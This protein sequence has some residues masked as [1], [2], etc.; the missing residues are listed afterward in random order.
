VGGHEINLAEQK[1]DRKMNVDIPTFPMPPYDYLAFL[2]YEDLPKS[3][4]LGVGVDPAIGEKGL[5]VTL[6]QAGSAAQR[7][8][9][10]K[11]DILLEF[12]GTPLVENFDLIYA[13]QQKRPGDSAVVKLKRGGEI[14]QIDV[15]FKTDIPAK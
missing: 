14:K 6:I 13:V 7:S 8:G 12:D 10:Q 5:L 11:G 2:A 3:I 9:L 15:S 1:E 4:R